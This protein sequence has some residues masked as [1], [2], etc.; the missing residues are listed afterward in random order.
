MSEMALNHSSITGVKTRSLTVDVNLN[1]F[2]FLGFFCCLGNVWI[3]S[4]YEPN[5]NKNTTNV[6]PYCNKTVYLFA[7]WTTTLVYILLSLVLLSG[8]CVLVCF[9]LCGRADADDV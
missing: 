6:D 8:C 1:I 4:I 9:Y 2:I 7:F 5:Y 3:Y